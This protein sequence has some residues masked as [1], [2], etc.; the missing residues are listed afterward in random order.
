MKSQNEAAVNATATMKPGGGG[1]YN[2][3][4]RKFNILGFLLMLKM[5]SIFGDEVV[6]FDRLG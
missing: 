1:V 3:R 6:T 4:N 5:E 2:N